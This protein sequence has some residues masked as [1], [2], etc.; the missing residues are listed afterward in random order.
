MVVHWA[1]RPLMKL[2][3]SQHTVRL[4]K[5]FRKSWKSIQNSPSFLI[6]LARSS[7]L[8]VSHTLSL[9]LHFPVH[10]WAPQGFISFT[11]QCFSLAA[12]AKTSMPL[13]TM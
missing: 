12:P 6:S 1:F 4:W 8:M 11:R 2:G 13:K 3:V 5:N 9:S 10:S 7:T